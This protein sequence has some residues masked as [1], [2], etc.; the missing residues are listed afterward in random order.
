MLDGISVRLAVHNSERMGDRAHF[1]RTSLLA[2]ASYSSSRRMQR[3]SEIRRCPGILRLLE[4]DC[5]ATGLPRPYCW[6]DLLHAERIGLSEQPV[7]CEEEGWDMS[8]Y[9][10]YCQYQGIDCARRARLARSPEIATYW[11]SLGF[12]WLR[13]AEQAE[14]TGGALGCASDEVEASSFHFSD[15]D[16]ERE[17]T[18]A[19][20]NADAQSL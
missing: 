18:R 9:A 13:L 11:R 8:S 2:C 4:C 6:M 7:R 17:T 14:G 12:R 20:A 1:L 16:L 15:S 5:C 10:S 3:Q 19:K